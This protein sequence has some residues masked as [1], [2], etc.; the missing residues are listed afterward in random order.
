[1]EMENCS[2]YLAL[3]V[4]IHRLSVDSSHKWPECGSS[5]KMKYMKY[6]YILHNIN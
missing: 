2:E 6:K 4:G 5:N 1:M 3:Y